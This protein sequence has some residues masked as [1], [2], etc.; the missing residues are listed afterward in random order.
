MH[1][2][3]RQKG[4]YTVPHTSAHTHTDEHTH[5]AGLFKA[6]RHLRE[7]RVKMSNSAAVTP[8]E[9][10][11]HTH[12]VHEGRESVEEASVYTLINALHDY[13]IRYTFWQ[14]VANR[15]LRRLRAVESIVY[16]KLYQGGLCI[17]CLG[18]SVMSYLVHPKLIHLKIL[19]I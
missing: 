12:A 13:F 1:E 2:E 14:E 7:M 16:K 6:P 17:S 18:P 5:T 10:D 11:M 4:A 19:S 9:R 8:R 3:T 15:G